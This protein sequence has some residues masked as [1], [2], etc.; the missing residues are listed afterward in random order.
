[1]SASLASMHVW[2]FNIY[3]MPFRQYLRT[4]R[5]LTSTLDVEASVLDERFKVE[6][7]EYMCPWL[8]LMNGSD[9][10]ADNAVREAFVTRELNRNQVNK[11][12]M[13]R[14]MG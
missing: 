2:G 11:V 3:C 7:F 10:S 4:R 12:S 14:L 9:S 5:I 13:G 1:M 8:V 6:W